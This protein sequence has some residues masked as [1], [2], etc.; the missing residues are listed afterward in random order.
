[1]AV[2]ASDGTVRGILGMYDVLDDK[3]AS[4]LF[5]ARSQAAPRG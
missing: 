4:G 1:M 2:L 5:F 3:T